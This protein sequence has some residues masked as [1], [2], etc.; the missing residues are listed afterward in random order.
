MK[1][2]LLIIVFILGVALMTIAADKYDFKFIDEYLA[3]WDRFANG[4]NKLVPYLN[5][6]R[7]LFEKEL[8]I[9]LR[10]KD[11]KAPAR[12]V[13]YAVVQVGGFVPV[14]SDLGKAI[15]PYLDKRFPTTEDT[16]KIRWYFAGDLYFWWEKN[17]QAYEPMPLFEEWKTRDFA[18]N[19]A[20]PMYN[21]ATKHP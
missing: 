1:T 10:A 20:I 13:F 2:P 11:K 9:A 4:E 17:K 14:D 3:N 6:K 7:P 16:D 5:E 19:T 18:K 12:L 15:A 8:A 21:A